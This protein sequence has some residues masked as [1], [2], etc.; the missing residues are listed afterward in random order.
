[1]TTPL[2]TFGPLQP[3][4]AGW[5]SAAIDIARPAVDLAVRGP[6]ALP[7]TMSNHSHHE[8]WFELLTRP[9]WGLAAAKDDVPADLWTALATTLARA[10]DP[11]DAW[12]VGDP[13]EG[14]QRQVEA[15][16]VGWGLA[17]APE[18]LW[19]PLGSKAKDAL[20]AWLSAAYLGPV[21]DNNWHYF[22][23]FAGHGLARVGVEHDAAVAAAHL[24][25]IGELLLDKDGTFEDG[26]GG[27]VDYYNPFAF[28]T[29]ALLHYKLGGDD[30]FA[31]AAAEFARRFGSW[32]AADGASV[33]YGRSL[34][35]RFAH[36]S[37]WGALVAADV[38]AVPWAEAAG[39]ARRNLAW[40]WDKPILDPE[41][42]LT[43]GYGYPNDA[44]V[45]QYLTTGS[46]WWAMKAFTGLLAGA[47]HPFWTAEAKAPAAGL[48]KA[49]RA[50]H[51]R[52][53]GGH[54]TRLNGQAWQPWSRGGQASYGK[55]AYSSVAAFSHLAE[56]PGLESAVPDGA[57]ML[58]EDGRHW[59]GRED[60][61]EGAIDANGV[62]TVNWQPWEDVTITTS[63]EAAL[64]GWHAR[65]HVIET[66]RTLHTGEGGWC[67]PLEGHI[68]EAEDGKAVATSQGL[69]SEIIDG[70]SGR[71]AEVITPMAGTH[72]YWPSTALPVLR[73]V[74]EPGKHV[75]K[76]LIYIGSEV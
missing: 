15:A 71:I 2:R 47:E 38:E 59:R 52:D 45:E 29:Y 18:R 22:P 9:L 41:G 76:S 7:V 37:L 64:D 67:V 12:Y 57:L 74:L 35:Y 48:H 75:L 1:M 30:R 54:V 20:A 24:D 69:R 46:P 53:H 31:A 55:L 10:V 4:H 32:F 72:L 27:R 28:H 56:G 44:V 60:S 5:T 17:L 21:A 39:Y 62:L 40:W 13:S 66:G 16:A 65:V 23:V 49:P 19:E 33:P 11:A 34:G 36:S 14:G 26:P 63:L 73:G 51:V 42:R 50:V 25:R 43:V 61:D 3:T 68:A 6:D 8:N 70:D 58:S